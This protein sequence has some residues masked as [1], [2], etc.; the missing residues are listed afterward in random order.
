MCHTIVE[1]LGALEE[2]S[3]DVEEEAILSRAADLV[4]QVVKPAVVKSSVKA[5]VK[6]LKASHTSSLRPHTLVA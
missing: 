3:N 6:E 1:I 5:V 4:V 2:L